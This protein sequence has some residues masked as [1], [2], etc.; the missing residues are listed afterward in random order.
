VFAG[1][2]A[3]IA[4]ASIYIP[5]RTQVSQKTLEQA[6]LSL[7]RAYAA[8]SKDGTE[9]NP[10]A[11]DRLNWLTAG[12]HLMGYT[13][14]KAQITDKV[15]KTICEEQEEYWRHRFYIS[16]NSNELRQAGYYLERLAPN[17][18]QPIDKRSALVVHAFAKWPKDRPDP[19]D[20]VNV[21]ELIEEGHALLGNPGLRAYIEDTVV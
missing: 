1:V 18:K 3:L 8:L 6:Q 16:L 15:H 4:A 13:R 9:E 21:N 2:S 14:L 17:P 5:A 10:P 19:L 20:D 7:E 12:R 11:P